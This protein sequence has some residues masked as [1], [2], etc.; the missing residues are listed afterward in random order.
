MNARF[1]T[2]LHRKGSNLSDR[3]TLPTI[4]GFREKFA[5]DNWNYGVVGFVVKA[6]SGLPKN[7]PFPTFG[8]D[9]DNCDP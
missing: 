9:E 8:D 2:T 6:I 4:E 7:P 5:Y 1:W 3:A